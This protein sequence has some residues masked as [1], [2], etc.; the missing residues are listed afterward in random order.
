MVLEVLAAEAESSGTV[1]VWLSREPRRV[2]PLSAGDATSRR[3]W[4]A[5]LVSGP[6]EHPIVEAVLAVEAAPAY[7]PIGWPDAW[8]VLLALDRRILAGASVLVVADPALESAD[9]VDALGADPAD[10]AT[11]SGIADAPR[12]PAALPGRRRRD[13]ANAPLGGAWR[14]TASGDLE[15]H[16]GELAVRKRIERRCLVVPGSFFHL[17]D[18]GAGEEVKRP[19]RGRAAVAARIRVQVAREEEVEGVE[20]RSFVVRGTGAARTAVKVRLRGD[21]TFEGSV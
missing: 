7:D 5:S 20:A 11:F 2:S 9:G 19:A 13:V 4:V 8:S 17:P 12:K 14:T 18:Y 15:V 3:T 16:G 6:G 10:R 21:R 1:R